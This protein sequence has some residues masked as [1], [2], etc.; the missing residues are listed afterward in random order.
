MQQ[1]A[2]NIDV[3]AW[4]YVIFARME[5]PIAVLWIPTYAG[6]IA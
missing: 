1:S 6:M 4:S 2:V 5:T 3:V